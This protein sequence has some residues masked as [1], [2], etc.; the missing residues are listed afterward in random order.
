MPAMVS[1]ML[2][3]IAATRSPCFD[4]E[5]A[6]RLLQA[7]DQRAQLVPGQPALD[8]VLAAEDDRVARPGFRSR[9]SAKFSRASGKKRAPGI[10][11]PSTSARSPFSPM[12]PQKSQTRS[13][14]AA[15]IVDRPAMQVGVGRQAAAGARLGGAP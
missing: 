11:S 9:F 12:T 1:G 6:Q 8:L 13:Q 14:N 5:R 10:R 7:R 4:A 15:A 2:G 3:S